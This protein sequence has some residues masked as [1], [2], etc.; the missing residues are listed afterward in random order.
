MKQMTKDQVL[1]LPRGILRFKGTEITEVPVTDHLVVR[2][3]RVLL[4]AEVSTENCQSKAHLM[5]L[6]YNLGRAEEHNP[7]IAEVPL[8]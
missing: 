5:A 8:D 1:A 7:Y 3:L 2:C 6:A 4:E